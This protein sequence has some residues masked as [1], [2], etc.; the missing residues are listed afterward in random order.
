MPTLKSDN[1]EAAKQ[2]AL[3]VEK[4]AKIRL[5]LPRFKYITVKVDRHLTIVKWEGI[6]IPSL[7]FTDADVKLIQREITVVIRKS[8]R[9]DSVAL[10]RKTI[11]MTFKT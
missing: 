4:V 9:F 6:S 1:S 2:A 3:I 8:C 7:L 11:A 5:K 10:D